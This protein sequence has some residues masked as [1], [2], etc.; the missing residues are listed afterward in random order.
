MKDTFSNSP[1]LLAQ[2]FL[3]FFSLLCF[4]QARK[5]F[6]QFYLRFSL[7]SCAG[8]GNVFFH[9]SCCLEILVVVWAL[10]FLA[11]SDVLLS[12]SWQVGTPGATSPVFYFFSF[13]FNLC[14]CEF[15]LSPKESLPL[16]VKTHPL[17]PYPPIPNLSPSPPPLRTA[18]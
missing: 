17:P 8:S 14:C 5:T 10:L 11:G 1:S 7:I 9:P 3:P 13:P 6:R 18:T 16:L 15:I 12:W 2:Q 4:I